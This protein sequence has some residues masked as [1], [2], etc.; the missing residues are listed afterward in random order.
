M[1]NSEI[2]RLVCHDP[3]EDK[4]AIITYHESMESAEGKR[5][6]LK[7]LGYRFPCSIKKISVSGESRKMVFQLNCSWLQD[8]K[9]IVENGY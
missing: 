2:Y 7:N 1:S 4:I 6:Y 3:H 5:E 8:Q 9:E